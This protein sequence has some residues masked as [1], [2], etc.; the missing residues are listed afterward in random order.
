VERAVVISLLALVAL[1]WLLYKLV[2]ALERNS[3]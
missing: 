1:T 3:Q 2:V